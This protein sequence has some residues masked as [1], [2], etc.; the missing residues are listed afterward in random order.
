MRL[1]I[2]HLVAASFALLAALGGAW[3]SYA[4][5]AEKS[6][7]AALIQAE[8]AYKTSLAESAPAAQ[9][10]R[11]EIA[12]NERLLAE[13]FVSKI[14]ID[15]FVANMERKADELGLLVQER[16]VAFSQI[17]GRETHTVSMTMSG[18]FDAL[19]RFTGSLEYS[20][21]DVSLDSLDLTH[22]QGM[23]WSADVAVTVGNAAR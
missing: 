1:T 15:A 18:T 9:A 8:A 4:A 20:P 14:E 10:V 17:N 6:A 5:L 12:R 16:E 2:P 13:F 7:A 11:A 3:S 23:L 21:Y 19:M 22:A